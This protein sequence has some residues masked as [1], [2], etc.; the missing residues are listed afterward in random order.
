MANGKFL[1]TGLPGRINH[2]TGLNI[3]HAVLHKG[4]MAHFIYPTIK[5][6]LFI[7]S[8]IKIND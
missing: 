8:L 3:A 2:Q 6:E 4:P 7:K 5:E 1:Q